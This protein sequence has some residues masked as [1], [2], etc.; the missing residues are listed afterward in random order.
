MKISAPQLFWLMFIG[1]SSL[2]IWLVIS[3]TIEI[4][5]QD[6]WVSILIAI[7]VGMFCSV[8]MLTL[9]LLFPNQTMIEYS[10]DIVGST[11]GTII[12]ILYLLSWCITDAITLRGILDLIHRILFNR[13]P[14]FMLVIL[15]MV[16]VAYLT[17]RGGIEG[18]ARFSEV[19]GPI[20]LFAFFITFVLDL[21]STKWGALLPVMTDNGLPAI[22]KGA[23]SFT[24]AFGVSFGLLALVPFMGEQKKVVKP[25]ISGLSLASVVILLSTFMVIATF[26]PHLAAVL[27]DPYFSMVRFISL[28]TCIRN[29]DSVIVFIAIFG[30][31][32]LVSLYFFLTCYGIGQLFRIQSWRRT[33]WFLGPIECII[34]I[35]PSS[36]TFSWFWYP[37]H[38]WLN[39][40][41]P[42]DILVLPLLLLL[43]AKIKLWRKVRPSS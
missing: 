19:V 18:I 11:F 1:L 41:F 14:V 10:R 13:T 42:V 30:A 28:Y 31:F 38:V 4:A 12:S 20:I 34:A 27:L 24:S 2:S 6:A 29:I 7:L 25:A 33:I 35:L 5:K 23:S 37:Q 36:D 39:Y 8:V 26:G 21:P 16:L 9:S 40:M 22:L 3:P 32:I 43:I 15:I 17:F